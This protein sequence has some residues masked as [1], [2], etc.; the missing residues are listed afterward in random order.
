MVSVDMDHVNN[1]NINNN[2]S[3]KI[4]HDALQLSNSQTSVRV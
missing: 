3:Q 4:W 1:N 2:K